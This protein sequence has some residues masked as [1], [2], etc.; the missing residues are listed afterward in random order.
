MLYTIVE[1]SSGST[2]GYFYEKFKLAKTELETFN[3]GAL[4]LEGKVKYAIAS[5]IPS[6]V[7]VEFKG[8]SFLAYLIDLNPDERKRFWEWY[9]V[10]GN[11]D[12]IPATVWDETITQRRAIA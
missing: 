3:Q 6:I 2:A 7:F 8:G 12:R 4:I 10:E 5:Y 1:V 9:S 11:S